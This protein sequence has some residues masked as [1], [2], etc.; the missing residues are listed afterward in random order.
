MTSP[1]PRPARSISASVAKRQIEAVRATAGRVL[2]WHSP[3]GEEIFCTYFSSTCGGVTSSVANL[4]PVPVIPPLAGGVRCTGCA[5][6]KYYRWP[7]VSIS[8]QDVTTKLRAS[9]PRPSARWG[10]SCGSSRSP[11]PRRDASPGW[12]SAMPA[13]DGPRC[14]RPVPPGG[15]ARPDAQYLVPDSQYADGIRVLRRTRFRPWCRH[16]PVGG[17]GHGPGRRNWQ[18]ILLHYYPSSHITRAY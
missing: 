12:F 13:A 1:A 4:H 7:A 18:Q 6:A 3:R 5:Q 8:R 2:T 9:I 17:R 14:A 15:W 11:P 16:V 10:R